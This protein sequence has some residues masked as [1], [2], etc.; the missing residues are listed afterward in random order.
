MYKR[1]ILGNEQFNETQLFAADMNADGFINVLDIVQMVNGILLLPR[2]NATPVINPKIEIENGKVKL[3]TQ[4]DVAGIQ[5]DV[6][7]DFKLTTIPHNWDIHHNDD[8]ILLFSMDG[9]SLNTDVL[10]E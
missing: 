7:G 5:L 3:T 4:G 9:S 1:Q 2:T 6:S 8:T 10:F